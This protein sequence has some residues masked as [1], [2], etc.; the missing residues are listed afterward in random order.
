MAEEL[1]LKDEKFVKEE[2]NKNDDL[3]LEEV[4]FFPLK[5]F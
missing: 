4:E 1:K 2:E 5:G 3:S